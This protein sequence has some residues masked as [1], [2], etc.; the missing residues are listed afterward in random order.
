VTVANKKFVMQRDLAR[1]TSLSKRPPINCERDKKRRWAPTTQA[2]VE[3]M[4]EKFTRGPRLSCGCRKRYITAGNDGILTIAHTPSPGAVPQVPIITTVAAF[5]ADNIH[6]KAVCLTVSAMRPGQSAEL[7]GLGALYC[8]TELNAVQSWI[9]RELPITQGIHGLVSVGGGKTVAGILAPLAMPPHVK[10][11]VLLAKPDQRIHYRNAYLRLREHFRVP[12]IMFDDDNGSYIVPNT[13]VLHLVPYSRLS[14]PKT[15]RIL[16]QKNPDA[17]IA[18]ESHKLANKTSA[19]TIRFLYL[20]ANKSDIIFCDWSG[21]TIKKSLK[22]ASHLAA[23]ALG[24]GSPYPILPTDVDQWAAVIDPSNMPDTKSQTAAD[25]YMTFAGI[26]IYSQ[27]AGLRFLYGERDTHKLREAFRERMVN[28]PGVVS[29][30]TSSGT[31]SITIKEWQTPPIPKAVKEALSGVRQNAVRPD[32]EELVEAIDVVMCAREVG[33]GWYSY[34]AYPK[35]EPADL[36][37][38][39]FSARK[40]FSK[41]MRKKITI[42]EPHMDSPLLCFNAAKRAWQEPKYEGD[43]PVWQE[44]SWL[45]W[46]AIKDKVRPEPRVRWIDEYLA[47]AAAEWATKNTGIVWCQ[48]RAFGLKVAQLAGLPYHAGGPNAEADIL[49]ESGA[50]SIIVSIDA[51]GTGRDGLQSK[52]YKQLIAEVPSSSDRWEQLL[53]RLNRP[54]QQADTIET[55]VCINTSET[56]DAMLKAIRFAEYVEATTPNRQ[57]ILAADM[58]FSL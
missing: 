45:A 58:E 22:D 32:G 46:A 10:T 23:H 17:I 14:N 21:S 56:K 49:A 33:S 5:C 12:T 15:S 31:S 51:H 11:V 54:G 44:E 42:G 53:G 39:W 24:L 43:L 2:L 16:D 41:A 38:E 13:P 3:V 7:E 19:A 29:T 27:K 57:L 1:I 55:E 4:T 40:I 30:T 8:L 26:D 18:D 9:L 50:R 6:D 20:M 35:G 36:I 28:T 47:R 34:W 25:L 48:S 37:T 52:Y